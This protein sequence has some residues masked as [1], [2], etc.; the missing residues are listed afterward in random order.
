MGEEEFLRYVQERLASL[1]IGP[2][3][4]R[5][6]GAEGVTKAARDFLSGRDLR[7]LRDVEP[8]AYGHLL[9]QWTEQLRVGLPEG[10]QNWG[11]ARKA[12]NVF[13]VEVFS[14]KYLASKYNMSRLGQVLE[15]P[16]DSQVNKKLRR[17]SRAHDITLPPWPGVRELT[18]QVSRQYQET[19]SQM[20]AELDLCRALLDVVIWRREGN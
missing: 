15:V 7:P 8:D 10:G 6:Q 5:N 11:T 20:A 1:V 13:L 3:T 18:P 16:L 17:F 14:N 9:D 12:L 19:A 4:L 2:T